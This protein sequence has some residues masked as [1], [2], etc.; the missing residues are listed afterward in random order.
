MTIWGA[1]IGRIEWR[2]LSDS[3]VRIRL[4]NRGVDAEDADAAVRHRETVEGDCFI[5]KVLRGT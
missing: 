2:D 4:E 3:E 5:E 1:G